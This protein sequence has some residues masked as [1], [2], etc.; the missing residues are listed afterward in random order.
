V[1]YLE[2]YVYELALPCQPYQVLAE[3]IGKVG[4]VA[5][6]ATL[7]I[8]VSLYTGEVMAAGGTPFTVTALEVG[9]GTGL[10]A[11]GSTPLINLHA[12]T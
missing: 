2:Y 5:A 11:H 10:A 8:N 9:G 12:Y 6:F 4:I 1:Y 7:A 3:R